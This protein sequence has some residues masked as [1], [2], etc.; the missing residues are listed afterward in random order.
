MFWGAVGIALLVW[1]LTGR[2]VPAVLVSLLPLVLE[3]LAFTDQHHW[4]PPGTI[5]LMVAL[6]ILAYAPY[7]YRRYKRS[8]SDRLMYGVR[9]NA[10]RD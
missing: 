2:L 10:R 9:F 1:W 7:A 5:R 8:R 4:D 6:S 3:W